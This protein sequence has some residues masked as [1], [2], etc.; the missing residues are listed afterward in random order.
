MVVRAG[1]ALVHA[2]VR[3]VMTFIAPDWLVRCEGTVIVL[4]A[5]GAAAGRAICT[6]ITERA[7][8]DLVVVCG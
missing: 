3:R 8:S 4:G 5:D 2:S 6:V 7:G 1:S